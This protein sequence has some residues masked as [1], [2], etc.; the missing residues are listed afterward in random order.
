MVKVV[1]MLAR[2]GV[3][4]RA[5]MPG[6]GLT[7]LMM[8]AGHALPET[9]ALLLRHCPQSVG[10]VDSLYRS[11]LNHAIRSEDHKSSGAE[12]GQT[13]PAV[14]RTVAEL[15]SAVRNEGCLWVLNR[16][17]KADGSTPLH[18][19]ASR[20]KPSLVQQLL[21]LALYQ[22]ET[23]D[24]RV[25]TVNITETQ[26]RH[27]RGAL[28][29]AIEQGGGEDGAALSLVQL[30]LDHG[31]PPMAVDEEGRNALM[32]AAGKG[33][34]KTVACLLQRNATLACKLDAHQ[35]CA[36][37]YASQR[38]AGLNRVDRQGLAIMTALVDAMEAFGAAAAHGQRQPQLLARAVWLPRPREQAKAQHMGKETNVVAA[39]ATVGEAQGTEVP[40][41]A[42]SG[43]R[44]AMKLDYTSEVL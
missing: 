37:H 38:V 3:D 41:P 34:A 33:Y 10:D 18:L 35:R 36:L 1:D 17:D 4:L 43:S 9:V 21:A 13:T 25:E 14:S 19:A 2:H 31:A 30:L 23:A 8:A 11:A 32:L 22:H 27:G 15:L 39:Q 44:Y 26:D 7:P 16:G 42:V 28:H 24:G 29:L 6:S 40:N 12:R 20:G 5:K